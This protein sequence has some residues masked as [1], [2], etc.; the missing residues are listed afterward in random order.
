MR[1]RDLR[2]PSRLAM[3]RRPVGALRVVAAVGADYVAPIDC[4]TY[5]GAHTRFRER[6]EPRRCAW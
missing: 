6:G 2:G 4:L 1:S 3:F 5:T